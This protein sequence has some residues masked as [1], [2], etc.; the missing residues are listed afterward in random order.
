MSGFEPKAALEA[1]DRYRVTHSQ[2][3]PTHFTRFLKMPAEDWEGHDLSSHRFAIHAAALFVYQHMDAVDGKQAR[4]TGNS[5]PLGLLFD[6]GCDALGSLALFGW[7]AA[8]ALL[9]AT[10]D[11]RR[12]SEV[13]GL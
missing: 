4:R 9:A 12:W 6:H 13:A 2:W 7:W 11:H 8:F 10:P 1:I 3:V 5:S